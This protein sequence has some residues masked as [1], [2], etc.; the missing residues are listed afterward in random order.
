MR[1]EKGFTIVELLIVIVVIAILAAI[2]IV[3]L[4]GIQQRADNTRTAQAITEYIKIAN[5]YAT[6]YDRYPTNISYPSTPPASTWLCLPSGTDATC[7]SDAGVT[8]S[9]FGLNSTAQNS[10]YKTELQRL[11]S[12]LPEPGKVPIDCTTAPGPANRVRGALANVTNTGRSMSIY[13]FQAGA[14]SPCPSVGGLSSARFV[15]GDAVRCI[16]TLP[17]L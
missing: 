14:S 5:M 10:V 2:A 4:S 11:G 3:S 1:P 16:V 8:P 12:A 6:S 7:G 17:N 9:C 15:A 13:F